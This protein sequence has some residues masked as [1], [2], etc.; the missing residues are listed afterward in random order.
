MHHPTKIN[1]ISH[2]FKKQKSDKIRIQKFYT[3]SGMDSAGRER[4]QILKQSDQWL[5]ETHDY[6]QWLFP[7]DEKSLF[8]A[9]APIISQTEVNE[10]LTDKGSTIERNMLQSFYRMMKFYGLSILCDSEGNVQIKA[11][12]PPLGKMLTKNNHNFLRL[13]RIMISMKLF[14][15]EEY[16]EALKLCLLNIAERYPD[17]IG[18]ETRTIWEKKC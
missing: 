8:N 6:I 7:T 18:E 10:I 4:L 1:F 3:D 17:I 16:S 11:K 9:D 13:S 14:G 15:L 2:I 5:E 12:E